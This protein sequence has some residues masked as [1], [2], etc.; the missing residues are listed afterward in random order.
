MQRTYFCC[1]LKSGFEKLV[2]VFGILLELQV[3]SSQAVTVSIINWTAC[4]LLAVLLAREKEN[5]ILKS[6]HSGPNFYWQ[7]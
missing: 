7:M 1:K 2:A 6:V 5:G 4:C 3:I